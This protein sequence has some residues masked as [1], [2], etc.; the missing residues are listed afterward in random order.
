MDLLTH[1]R[2]FSTLDGLA[3]ALLILGWFWVGWRIEH[4]SKG[5]PSVSVLMRQYRHQWMEQMITR[6]PR[7]FDATILGALR[8]GI[9]FFA[10]ACLIVIG[11][12]LALIGN[13]ERLSGVAEDLQ[14]DQA[15]AVIWEVKIL[16]VLL[17]VT[18]AL[19][20]FIWAHRLFGYCAV[21]M[22]ATPN[23]PKSAIAAARATQ[24]AEINI[25]AAAAFNRGL[26]SVYFALGAIA[27]IAGP[28]ALMAAAATTVSVLWR[29]EFGSGS[30][31]VLMRFEAQ[32]GVPTQTPQGQ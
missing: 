27:W 11:G 24:A 3:V 15:P 14:F 7:I 1:I 5:R 32:T 17:F 19:L 8:E 21:V 30:R 2:F 13:P 18:N 22:A 29:R 4:P 12:G 31:R 28:F 20:K 10:S 9:T 26:R 6:Q 25:S 23:D 16:L